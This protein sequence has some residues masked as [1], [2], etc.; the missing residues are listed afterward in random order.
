M[1]PPVPTNGTE[2]AVR[3]EIVKLVVVALVKSDEE[4]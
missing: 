1:S 2:P 3:E 4:A